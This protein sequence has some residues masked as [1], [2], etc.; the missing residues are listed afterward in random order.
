MN[1]ADE[2]RKLTEL[3][4]AG[5]LTDQ[6][7]TDAKR[8]LIAD[9]GAE[10]SPPRTPP[11]LPQQS[12][13]RKRSGSLRPFLILCGGILAIWIIGKW[14][15]SGSQSSSSASPSNVPV[16]TATATSAQVGAAPVET[17]ST[18]SAPVATPPPE[19]T[20]T[21]A[22]SP[23]PTPTAF[24]NRVVKL[25]LQGEKPDK[26]DQVAMGM[27]KKMKWSLSGDSTTAAKED[28]QQFLSVASGMKSYPTMEVRNLVMLSGAESFNNSLGIEKNPMYVYIDTVNKIL[29]F[30]EE[31]WAKVLGKRPV[32]DVGLFSGESGIREINDIITKSLND[33]GSFKFDHLDANPDPSGQAWKVDYYFRAKNP[34]G[35]L[36]LD[37]YYFYIR[38]GEVVRAEHPKH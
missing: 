19:S 11:P 21:P 9:A 18:A 7:F 30:F 13:Q 6:E 23:T 5:H 34:F 28:A 20:A 26:Y 14:N 29:G 3:H 4:E 35:A 31:Y 1:L 10:P 27:I 8:R 2:L 12:P 36:M 24:K 33:P 22:P 37:H 16:A 15:P 17:T 38:N 32:S 25:D